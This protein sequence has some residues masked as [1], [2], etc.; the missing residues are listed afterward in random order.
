MGHG[1]GGDAVPVTIECE[2]RRRGP[3]SERDSEVTMRL[4]GGLRSRAFVT[5]VL[6]TALIAAAC[7]GGDG[8]G[9]GNGSV[10]DAGPSAAGEDGRIRVVTTVSP[11]R[12]IVESVGGDRITVVG[13]VPEGT[14][15]HTFEP[16]PSAARV[17]AE[18]DLVIVNGLK[19]E[20]PALE[21]AE[22]NAE[23]GVEILLLGENTIGTDEYV[24]DFSFP[25]DL[26]SPNPHLW[27]AP[28]LAAQYGGLVA[29]AL[30]R[31]DPDG[32]AYYAENLARFQ[33]RID[34]M[35]GRFAEALATIPGPNRR[36]LTYH[37]SFP[38]FG[39]RYDLE[40]IGAVQPSDFSAPSPREVAG[41][42]EQIRALGVP[43]IFGSEVF[44]SKVLE[45]I[46]DEAGAVQVS[47]LRDDDLPGER[48][49]AD[50]TYFAMM[51]ENVRTIA[52]A[53]G[54]SAAALEG[55]DVTNSWISEATFRG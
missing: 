1:P 44:D 40:I 51:A 52:T 35:D 6:G 25:E 28:N 41:L 43:A 13:L 12:S 8:D 11:I 53:L 14:N 39:S 32:G 20:L 29:E 7:G 50:N 36:L 5:A 10:S 3:I 27:T 54:G 33:V 48:G 22:A 21:L 46:A 31:V 26:G 37:D 42:I 47:T 18:A 55:F 2:A 38:F 9:V 16:A 34:E 4:L 23:P 49:E 24:F 17:L 30:T 45:I 15:S 19:L